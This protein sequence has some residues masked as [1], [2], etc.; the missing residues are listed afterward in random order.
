MSCLQGRQNAWNKRIKTDGALF[1]Q[2][3]WRKNPWSC[4]LFYWIYQ[5]F[6]KSTENNKRRL[7]IAPVKTFQYYCQNCSWHWHLRVK[8][9]NIFCYPHMESAWEHYLEAKVE[10]INLFIYRTIC[11]FSI[12]INVCLIFFVLTIIF[13]FSYLYF[14]HVLSYKHSNFEQQ[15]SEKK[16]ATTQKSETEECFLCCSEPSDNSI[17]PALLTSEAAG[18]RGWT[19]LSPPPGIRPPPPSPRQP[20]PR[21]TRNQEHWRKTR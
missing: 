21:P 20:P 16:L 7:M 3:A 9:I 12:H 5:E 14:W 18:C 19:S 4:R 13:L 8:A 15:A 11:F 17:L 6:W 2:L 10:I 1:T